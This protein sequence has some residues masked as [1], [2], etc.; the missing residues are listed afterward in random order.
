MVGK[1]TTHVLDTANGCP[2][3]AMGVGLRVI[4]PATQQSVLLKH[5]FTNTD[6]RTDTPM[7]SPAE[8]KVG[9]YELVFEVDAYFRQRGLELPEPAFL[10]EVTLRFG[11]ADVESHYHVPLLVSP[12]SYSTYRGS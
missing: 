8:F 7:L 2:A 10:G 11:I 3:A 1:L 9:Q 12:W 4:D 5:T 6:G